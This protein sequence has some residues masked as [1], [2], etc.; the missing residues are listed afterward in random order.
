MNPIKTKNGKELKTDD[1]KSPRKRIEKFRKWERMSTRTVDAKT[2]KLNHL[3]NFY[4]A[5]DVEYFRSVCTS[6]EWRL[7]N[8]ETKSVTKKTKSDV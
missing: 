7:F 1:L 3:F 4:E 5:Q 8:L 6:E 2:K